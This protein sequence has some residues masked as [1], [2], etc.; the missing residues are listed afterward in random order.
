MSEIR[1]NT[2]RYCALLPTNPD[3]S[4]PPQRWVSLRS[5]HPTDSRRRLLD[6]QVSVVVD[7]EPGLARFPDHRRMPVDLAGVGAADDRHE[8]RVRTVGQIAEATIDADRHVAHVALV[9]IDRALL[10]AFQPEHL[11]APL[12]RNE[13]FLRRMPVQGGAFPL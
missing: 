12:D 13:H 2:F 11:P 3:V 1:R 8:E 10:I 5:T 4:A 6:D 7:R 9:E